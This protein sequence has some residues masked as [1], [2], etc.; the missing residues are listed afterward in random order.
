M[1]TKHASEPPSSQDHNIS[2]L[3]S[4]ID[5]QAVDISQ[6]PPSKEVA[7]FYL[8]ARLY[9]VATK[10]ASET[11]PYQDRSEDFLSNFSNQCTC[12]R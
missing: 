6:S 3:I 2:F 10:V 9:F 11:P 1:A 7:K 12:K 8:N 5:A 4:A